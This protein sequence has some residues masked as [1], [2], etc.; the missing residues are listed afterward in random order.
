VF[1]LQEV[2]FPWKGN[3]G[4]LPAMENDIHYHETVHQLDDIP[5]NCCYNYRY[6]MQKKTRRKRNN[7]PPDTK[8]LL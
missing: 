7:T 5:T 4:W 1:L 3:Q 2:I 8:L 6:K